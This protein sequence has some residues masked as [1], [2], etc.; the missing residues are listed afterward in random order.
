MKYLKY[1]IYRIKSIYSPSIKTFL[2]WQKTSK[3][4]LDGMKY[5]IKKEE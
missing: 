1:I 2:E 4:M 5:G 3:A